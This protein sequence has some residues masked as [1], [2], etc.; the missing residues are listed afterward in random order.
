[1]DVE[2]ASNLEN[3]LHAR[4]GLTDR[5]Q[6]KHTANG[7]ACIIDIV[8]TY[9]GWVG[10]CWPAR[11]SS[12]CLLLPLAC[13]FSLVRQPNRSEVSRLARSQSSAS[14]SRRRL[15]VGTSHS[16]PAAFRSICPV[17]SLHAAPRAP[18][19]RPF[20]ASLSLHS[21]SRLS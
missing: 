19:P 5:H 14:I 21:L 12:A 2:A 8:L 18:N 7:R 10:A 15:A 3:G 9:W 6:I 20:P 16:V 11:R 1:V 4:H 17:H 13:A